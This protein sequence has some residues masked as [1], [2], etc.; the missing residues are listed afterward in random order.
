MV[1]K[2]ESRH[3]EIKA[4]LCLQKNHAHTSQEISSHAKKCNP[5]ELVPAGCRIFTDFLVKFCQLLHRFNL[6]LKPGQNLN[7]PDL[8]LP[9]GTIEM[10]IGSKVRDINSL[11]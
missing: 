6:V 2:L 3:G 7:P 1:P 4:L 5:C 11:N 10:E 9:Q 8:M